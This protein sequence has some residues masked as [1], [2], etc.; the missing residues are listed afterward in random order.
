MIDLVRVL[1]ALMRVMML[2]WEFPPFSSGGLGTHCYGLV[3]AMG[4]KDDVDITFVMPDEEGPPGTV[5]KL[6]MKKGRIIKIGSSIKP[7][8]QS[9][10]MLVK[11]V[12]GKK[13]S[14]SKDFFDSVVKYN[15][16]A[17]EA[18]LQ[19]EFDVIHCHDWMT[20]MAGV[21]LKQRTKK[22]LVVTVHSTE[23]DR[24]GDNPNSWISHIEWTGTYNADKVITVSAMMK[25][26]LITRY[27]VPK[28]KIEVIYNA[29][30]HE[31]FT[32]G[33]IKSKLGDK[34]VLF[35][36]RVT[37]Q[38]GLDY[39]LEA[40]KLVVEKDKSVKFVIVGKGDQLH[41]MIER[42]VHLGVINNVFFIGYAP[43]IEEFYKM[44][45]VYVM[46]SVSEPFG[47]V[48]LE[49]MA[50]GTPVI[51]SKRSGVIEVAKHMMTV[52][53]WDVK[54]L[55]NKILGVVTHPV[56][57]YEMG[58]NG[59]EEVKNITWKKTAEQTMRVYE[60]AIEVAR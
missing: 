27:G 8:E 45:D 49:A 37:L 40:A 30:R 51:A 32:P 20:F 19:E 39:L 56:V 55:A 52:D 28:E 7:Y 21:N 48:A 6:G 58:K 43:S 41:Q 42:A 47:I 5:R 23:S 18:A 10:K 57:G 26:Q 35:L 44:A 50:C 22:P 12:G 2:G 29:V 60:R 16:V 11:M 15:E 9:G 59:L 17:V 33:R 34:I 14:Y 53:F 54:E 1:G 31:D 3:N 46:P 13:E 38:K 25:D 36:G 24:T 4:E